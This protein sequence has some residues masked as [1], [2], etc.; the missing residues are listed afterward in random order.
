M[1]VV[2]I[3]FR[4]TGVLSVS[5][6]GNCYTVVLDILPISIL[7]IYNHVHFMLY[8]CGINS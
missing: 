3:L 8:W 1:D 7:P 5:Y 4:K 2:W 6:F